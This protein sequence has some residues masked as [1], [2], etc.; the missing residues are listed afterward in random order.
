ME[1]ANPS[2]DAWS[3]E[4]LAT[5]PHNFNTTEYEVFADAVGK[6]AATDVS[7]LMFYDR[8]KGGQ[9]LTCADA[10]SMSVHGSHQPALFQ[11]VPGMNNAQLSAVACDQLGNEV[12]FCMSAL[13]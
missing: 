3:P 4:W 13:E 2:W 8:G 9:P 5:L 11:F 6:R 1:Q 12:S 10:H 7:M